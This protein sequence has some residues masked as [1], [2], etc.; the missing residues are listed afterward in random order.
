MTVQPEPPV[1]GSSRPAEDGMDVVPSSGR[2]G[3]TAIVQYFL[4]LGADSIVDSSTGS[5]ASFMRWIIATARPS[6]T[7]ALGQT[8]STLHLSMRDAVERT[9]QGTRYIAVGAG[10]WGDRDAGSILEGPTESVLEV[11]DVEE[12]ARVALGSDSSVDLLHVSISGRQSSSS[13]VRPWL[14][15]LGPGATVVFTG[16]GGGMSEELDRIAKEVL[17]DHFRTTRVPLGV[18]GE[19]LVAQEPIDGSSRSVALLENVPGAVGSMLTLFGD[20][21]DAHRQIRDMIGRPAT[22]GPVDRLLERHRMERAAFLEALRTYQDLMVQLSDELAT[23]RQGLAAQTEAARL[24]R[25]TLVREFLDR[26]DLLAA[27][28]S[29][30]ASKHKAELELKERQLEDAENRV[31]AYAGL[32]ASAQDVVD[33]LRRS[34]S[35]RLT[36][37][38]RLFSG[39]MRRRGVGLDHG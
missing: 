21:D 1:T 10:A 32:A 11:F 24:E 30:G 35:W 15:V 34:S 36:A 14:D 17:P 37:P 19:A 8:D 20:D 4:P 12:D 6:V 26:V 13:D 25:E 16:S 39:L 22:E 7:V 29:T 27:K 5:S 9:G 3:D 31:L 33:D 23:E 18:D 38:L 2:S 28:V